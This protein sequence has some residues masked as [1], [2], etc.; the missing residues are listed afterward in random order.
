MLA[1]SAMSPATTFRFP[2]M[3]NAA[4]N[5][6]QHETGL[7]DDGD[8]RW[9]DIFVETGALTISADNSIVDINQILSTQLGPTLQV[10]AYGQYTP[11]GAETT[12]GPYTPR[13][14]GYTDTRISARN[15]RLRFAP[16]ADDNFGIGMWYLDISK[17]SGA[18]R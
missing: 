4:G 7:T 5:F 16:K 3:G 13:T 1:R 11:N 9:Q 14:D 10:T 17:Q 6:Y 15:A 8:P 2:F 18:R 12:F